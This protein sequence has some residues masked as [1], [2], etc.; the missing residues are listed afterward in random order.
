VR[1]HLADVRD[2]LFELGFGAVRGEV[3]DLRLEGDGQVGGGLDDAGAELVDAG[4][5]AAHRAGQALGLGIQAHAKHRGVALL[6]VLQHLQKRHGSI[7]RMTH[8]RAPC[9]D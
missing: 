6:R 7:V 2:E 9:N 4:R 5:V 3:G 1:R 8:N